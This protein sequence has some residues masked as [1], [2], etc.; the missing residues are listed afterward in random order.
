MSE[1]IRIVDSIIHQNL[2]ITPDNN[3]RFYFDSIYYKQYV[4]FTN[5]ELKL[6]YV[7]GSMKYPEE[8]LKS[9]V[10]VMGGGAEYYHSIVDISSRKVNKFGF[11]ASR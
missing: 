7:N 10:N 6:V 5:G 8:F 4:G 2:I 11:N 1:D 3:L 9:L